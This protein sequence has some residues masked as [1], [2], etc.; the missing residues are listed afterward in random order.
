M[1]DQ[2]HDNS[3]SLTNL[4]AKTQIFG[5]FHKTHCSRLPAASL[6][7]WLRFVAWSQ[8]AELFHR[9]CSHAV[10]QMSGRG[11]LTARNPINC[12]PIRILSHFGAVCRRSV[13][14]AEI[15]SRN[16]ANR[17]NLLLLIIRVITSIDLGLLLNEMQLPLSIETD[18]G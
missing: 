12:S 3:L 1:F 4:S 18:H 8:L 17:D 7:P 10:I 9:S 6:S 2:K 11:C 15:R 14:S 13:L 16:P 5:L